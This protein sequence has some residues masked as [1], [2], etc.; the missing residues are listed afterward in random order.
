MTLLLHSYWRATAPYR[1]RIGLNLKGLAYDYAPIHLV[2]GVQHS[3]AYKAVNRQE[4]L[5]AL[6]TDDGQVLTQSLAILEWLEEVHPEPALLPKTAGDRAVVRAMAAI[7]ACDIHPLNNLR[8]Q[9]QLTA[10]GVDDAGRDL[11]SKRWI[12]DGF[13]AL[14]PMVAAH[15]AGFAFGDAPTLADCCLIPQVYSAG[16]Y[17]VALDPYPAIA[18][19]AARA[20]EHPAFAAAHPDKQPDAHPA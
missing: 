7:V 18:A 9:Q 6:T 15:G 16:R 17:G 5:P 11:W 2:K 12:N 19:V 14:E 3:D 8:I 4:L 20:A 1:V 13:S 10:L